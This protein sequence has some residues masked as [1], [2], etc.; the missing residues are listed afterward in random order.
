M[1]TKFFRSAGVISAVLGVVLIIAL[2]T[3]FATVDLVYMKDGREVYRQEKV[4]VISKIDDPVA[5]M[6]EEF[7]TEGETVE[8]TY[9]VHNSEKDFDPADAGDL[10]MDIV[11]TVLTNLFTFKW[12]ELDNDIVM[13]AK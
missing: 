2:F 13:Q 8:F 9:T 10:K 6:S 5:N 4:S 12:D 3:V 11:K 7:V 1:S